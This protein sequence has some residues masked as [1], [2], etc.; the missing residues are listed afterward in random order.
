MKASLLRYQPAVA[1]LA[2]TI[3]PVLC[4]RA[5]LLTIRGLLELDEL[6]YDWGLLIKVF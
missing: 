2:A 5:R 6:A 4:R 3:M 1:T